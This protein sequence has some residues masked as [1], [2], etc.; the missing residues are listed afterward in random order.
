MPKQGRTHISRGISFSPEL[1]ERVKQRA[2][3]LRMNVSEYIQKCLE[4]EIAKGGDFVIHESK[5]VT[6]EKEDK[7]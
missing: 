7:W 1:L 3:S 4:Q 6:T 2:A 5:A